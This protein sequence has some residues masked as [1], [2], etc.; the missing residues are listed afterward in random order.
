[1]VVSD[2]QTNTPLA[3]AMVAAQGRASTITD[4]TGRAVVHAAIGERLTITRLGYLPRT[5]VVPR[6]DADVIDVRMEP[7]AVQLSRIE[8][9]S[10]AL[11]A[12][13]AIQAATVLGSAQLAERMAASVADIIAAEPGVAARS[14]GPLATQPVIRGLAGDRVLVL[15]DGLRTGDVSTTAPDHVVSIEPATARQI[16]VIR[17]P[18]GLLYGSNT[19]GG[20]VNVRRE[21]VPRSIP[22]RMHWSASVHG[23]SMNRGLATAGRMLTPI[24]KFVLQV[25]GSGRTAGDTRTP[26]GEPL[27]F[28]DLDG[29]DAGLGVSRVEERGHIGVAAREYRTYYGVPSSFRG[30]T[31]PGAHEGGVYVDVRRTTA[32]FDAEWRPAHRFLDA[33]SAGG[34]AVR[35]EHAEFEQGGFVGTRFAQL[36]SSGEVVA[37]TQVGRHRAAAGATWQWRDLRAEGSYTGTRPATHRTA[38]VFALNE[39]TFGATTL[40]AGL[41]F[42]DIRITPLDSTETLLLRDVRTRRFRAL[43]GA[44]G[45]RRQFTS[46]WSLGVQLARAFRPPSIEE[47]FSAG[48]HL[49]SYAYEVGVPELR[50]ERG[51]GLDAVLRRETGNVRVELTGYAMRVR[52][53]VTFRPQIDST[54]GLPMRDPRLRR[55]VVYRPHQENAVL[56]GVEARVIVIPT[57]RWI[58]DVSGDLARGSTAEGAPLPFMPPPTVRVHGRHLRSGWSAG[59]VLDARFPQH[60]V[61]AAPAGEATCQLRIQDAEAIVRPAEFCPSAGVLLVGFTAGLELE[62]LGLRFPAL[63]SVSGDNLLD[64]RWRDPLWRAGL[65]APQPGRNIRV[66]VQVNR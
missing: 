63:L 46:E 27:P 31:L 65:V 15:E 40:L 35:Y 52:D 24:G 48:P 26:G 6:S 8:I 25:D 34:N 5:L 45:V 20:V 51:F 21:D 60:R 47:L 22:D 50:A 55:Y 17:G 32:R 56:T 14:N 13:E 59:L 19:L 9:Q 37:R 28:T 66:G 2:A 54:T 16:D 42:D 38:G 29:F 58:V 23:E 18:A 30:V 57:A 41:R 4:T 11:G 61:P 49:A 62:R 12:G 44:L 1:M 33:V 36:A 10:R 43:T 39:M 64:A 3:N 7:L 53:Y